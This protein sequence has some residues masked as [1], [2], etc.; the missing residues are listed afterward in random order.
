MY[1][2][3]RLTNLDDGWFG[4]EM[5]SSPDGPWRLVAKVWGNYRAA[6]VID[7]FRDGRVNV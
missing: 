6:Q 2:A 1:V 3:Y 4:I 5:T 7:A